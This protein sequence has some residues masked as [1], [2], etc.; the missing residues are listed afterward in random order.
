LDAI[1][2]SIED[3]SSQRSILRDEE[4]GSQKGGPQVV[5][6]HM[7]IMQTN[8]VTV[9]SDVNRR[10]QGKARSWLGAPNE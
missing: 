10:S 6:E 4:Q 9:T 5:V 3:A 7:G 2:D 1:E 8:T